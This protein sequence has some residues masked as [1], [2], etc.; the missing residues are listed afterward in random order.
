MNRLLPKMLLAP[1]F[2]LA[3]CAGT[4]SQAPRASA[5]S[6]TTLRKPTAT[7]RF[8]VSN[9]GPMDLQSQYVVG[10]SPASAIRAGTFWVQFPEISL[11]ATAAPL[12]ASIF[13]RDSV[14]KDSTRRG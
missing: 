12:W 4:A 3:A 5:P 9:S 7:H 10:V 1:L 8:F 2:A 6:D 13:L 14:V 11:F